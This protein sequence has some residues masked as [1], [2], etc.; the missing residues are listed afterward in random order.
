[1]GVIRLLLAFTVIMTH[2]HPIFGYFFGNPVVA[3]RAFFIISGFYMALILE[4]KYKDYRKFFVSRFLRIYPIYL[5]VLILTILFSLS[6]HLLGGSWGEMQ[7]IVSNFGQFNWFS[8]AWLAFSNLFVFGRD[9]L[10][11]LFLN[12]ANGLFTYHTV[13]VPT[14]YFL[15]IPQA[16]TIILEIVFYLIV[17]F[18]IKKR[19]WF[20]VALII[21]SLAIRQVVLSSGL[22]T[23]SWNYMFFPSEFIFFAGGILAFRL[24]RRI[25][26]Q[27]KISRAI[28][29]GASFI[30]V[31]YLAF[32]NYINF[33][34]HINA[35]MLGV[36]LPKEILFYLFFILYLPFIFILSQK[37]ELDRKIGELS[38]PVY[39]TH[40]LVL[41]MIYPKLFGLLKIK[42]D[43][44][45]L[46]AFIIAVG[47]SL[48]LNKYIQGPIDNFRHTRLLKAQS[49]K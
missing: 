26:F 45:N 25:K 4:S 8:A 46:V 20:I 43:Y 39:I 2:S 5:M 44:L 17:P 32:Y 48:L 33:D 31:S 41:S 23:V 24:Y 47:L 3:V 16:W 19:T 15:L 12:P 1:V 28:A 21:F 14:S 10:M 49:S 35:R 11:F 7:A 6:T 13:G 40:I 36:L 42:N 38:Y 34:I 9:I 37:S 22:N 27:P 29:V 30:I 18:I